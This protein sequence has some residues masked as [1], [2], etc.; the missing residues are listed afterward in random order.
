MYKTIT[1]ERQLLRDELGK[2]FIKYF[3]VWREHEHENYS[4][5]NRIR[6][7]QEISKEHYEYPIATELEKAGLLI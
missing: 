7:K 1:Y 5:K 3:K 6:L 4:G 2:T